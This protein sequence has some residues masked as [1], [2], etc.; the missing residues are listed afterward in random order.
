MGTEEGIWVGSEEGILMGKASTMLTRPDAAKTTKIL[1][2]TIDINAVI[3][4]VSYLFVI[5]Y[6][7]LWILYNTSLSYDIIINTTY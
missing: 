7:L 3:I 4:S 1:S 5:R 2:I 6:N